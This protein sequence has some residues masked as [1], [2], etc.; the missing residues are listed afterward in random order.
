M[1][2]V[3]PHFANN[4]TYAPG[5]YGNIVARELTDTEPRPPVPPSTDYLYQAAIDLPQEGGTSLEKEIEKD[6]KQR[7]KQLKAR[8]TIYTARM[9]DRMD[10]VKSIGTH[11]DETTTSCISRSTLAH[12][13]YERKC[14]VQSSV[15]NRRLQELLF[16]C[17]GEIEKACLRSTLLAET[18]CENVVAQ[19][20]QIEK[21]TV[22]KEFLMRAEED[23]QQQHDAP[24]H[25]G[26][27]TVAARARRASGRSSVWVHAHPSPGIHPVVT[28]QMPNRQL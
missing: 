1:N 11:F 18:L 21:S 7:L 22:W 28:F 6:F 20:T 4:V 15:A 24:R 26:D 12:L 13:L 17:L 8:H 25:D 27:A 5:V 23:A 9:K 3:V 14:R 19:K 16:E 2:N 10:H